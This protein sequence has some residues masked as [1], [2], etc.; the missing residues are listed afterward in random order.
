MT[1]THIQT[2]KYNN[3]S[4]TDNDIYP[5]DNIVTNTEYINTQ[6]RKLHQMDETVVDTYKSQYSQTM[7]AGVIWTV[8]ATSLTYYVFNEL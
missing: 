3:N 4:N 5:T 2:A 6:T 1:W 7:V 8:L